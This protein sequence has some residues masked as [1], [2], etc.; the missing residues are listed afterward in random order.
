MSHRASWLSA[1]TRRMSA[2]LN[3]SRYDLRRHYHFHLAGHF[4]A[5]QY[6]WHSCIDTGTHN[7]RDNGGVACR[8]GSG[9]RLG[10]WMRVNGANM[11]SLVIGAAVIV[12]GGVSATANATPAIT[13]NINASGCVLDSRSTTQANLYTQEG[14]VSFATGQTGTIYLTC[15]IVPFDTGSPSGT[16]S[17]FLTADYQGG[18]SGPCGG[19]TSSVSVW[20]DYAPI[21]APTG[22]SN[23][24][25]QYTTHS[26]S[27]GEDPNPNSPTSFSATLDFSTNTYWVNVAIQRTNTNCQPKF[28][29]TVVAVNQL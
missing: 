6:L 7:T 11:K 29:G 5:F 25:S 12:V 15:P 8:R 19:T 23:L 13:W 18:G 2:D 27:A 17:L 21:L 16:L 3:R 28:W 20:L 4:V 14:S 26:T 22:A 9:H 1:L 10:T 24:A